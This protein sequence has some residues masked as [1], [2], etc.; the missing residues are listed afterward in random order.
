MGRVEGVNCEDV[1][2]SCGKLF[3]AEG[4]EELR[5]WLVFSRNSKEVG[6]VGREWMSR[7]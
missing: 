2:T 6:V 4:T 5:A 3:Q 1:Q 7:R